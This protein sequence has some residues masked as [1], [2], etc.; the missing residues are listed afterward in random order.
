MKTILCL[1]M[2]VCAVNANSL[3]E[4]IVAFEVSFKSIHTKQRQKRTQKFPL[5]IVDFL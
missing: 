5:M 4:N 2:V 1:L 3:L